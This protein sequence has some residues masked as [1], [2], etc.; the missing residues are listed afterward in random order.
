MMKAK[1]LTFVLWGFL[2]VILPPAFGVWVT[3][4]ISMANPENWPDF[5]RF[6]RAVWSLA[7]T[8]MVV[9]GGIL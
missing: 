7:I 4:D 9:L 5:V 6:M 8:A 3:W 2:A 1:A